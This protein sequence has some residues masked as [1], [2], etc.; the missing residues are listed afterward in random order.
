MHVLFGQDAKRSGEWSVR[1][2]ADSNLDQAGQSRAT[3]REQVL[4]ELQP[5]ES[6]Y[7]SAQLSGS[8]T[9]QVSLE[10]AQ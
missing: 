8:L 10:Q 5:Y 1:M 2:V 7:T 9:E 4:Q 3:L 6:T